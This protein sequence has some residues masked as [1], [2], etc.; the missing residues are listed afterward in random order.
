MTPTFLPRLDLDP[1]LYPGGV[2]VWGALPAIY[3]TTRLPV[4]HG[5]HVHA[6]QA[7]KQKKDID[8]SYGEVH[9]ATG[10]STVVI[11][12][13]A[14]TPFVA[15]AV[16]GLPLRDIDCPYCGAPHLDADR[17][18]IHPHQ[19][20]LCE[21]CGRDFLEPDRAVGNPVLIAKR[22][23]ND[24][25][26]TRPTTPGRP[27]PLRIKQ[28][29]PHFAGGVLVWASNPAILW[30]AQ[31]DEADGIHVHA[32]DGVQPEPV[33]DDTYQRVEIDGIR[34]D[35][36]MARVFM[37]QQSLPHLRGLV[38]RETCSK[39]GAEH[40]DETVPF[41]VEPHSNHRCARCGVM[42]VTQSPLI[43]NPIVEVLA[44]LYANA[45]KAGLRKNPVAP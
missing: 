19:R 24:I 41:A 23:L 21:G 29:D 45:A 18:A 15:G 20:H 42:H 7:P 11:T 39:C 26:L 1:A 6:R 31:R 13:A 2:G 27:G 5:V 36:S 3:D 33:V 34:L 43:A 32:F 8:G 16:L 22:Q 25:A 9:I 30:T 40:F 4:E 12:E 14:A 44:T 28:S 37:V 10:S 35:P 38:Q 17:F